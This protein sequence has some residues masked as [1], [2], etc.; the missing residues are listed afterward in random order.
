MMQILAI[1]AILVVR[2]IINKEGGPGPLFSM[3]LVHSEH[4]E[5]F[6]KFCEKTSGEKCQVNSGS[7]FTPYLKFNW[8]GTSFWGY[9]EG[10]VCSIYGDD[11]RAMEQL[12]GSWV[13]FLESLE[14]GEEGPP[15]GDS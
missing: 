3:L 8:M 10:R 11:D 2:K 4:L 7:K 12:I 14:Y 9:L 5:F 13:S 1:R 15:F 6:I